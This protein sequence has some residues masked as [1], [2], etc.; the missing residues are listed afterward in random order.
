M[1]V[2]M[3]GGGPA[4]HRGFGI[5][6][7]RHL[8]PSPL[9]PLYVGSGRPFHVSLPCGLI[10]LNNADF[11]SACDRATPRHARSLGPLAQF[12]TSPASS[13]RVVHLRQEG[14]ESGA[15]KLSPHALQVLEQSVTKV[16][17]QDGGETP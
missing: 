17:L 4:M 2:A 6:Q 15:H 11:E 1:I 3:N 12:C 14:L 10:G 9:C 5:R 13:E 8:R 7:L 16:A